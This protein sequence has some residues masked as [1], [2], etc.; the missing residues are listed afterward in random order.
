MGYRLRAPVTFQPGLSTHSVAVQFQER[1]AL[2]MAFYDLALEVTERPL[3]YYL[4]AGGVM[5][6]QPS[7]RK[8]HRDPSTQ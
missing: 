6:I 4:L 2:R 7:S 3:Q 1:K 8:R 5:H